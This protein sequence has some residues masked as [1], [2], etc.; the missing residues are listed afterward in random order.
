VSDFKYNIKQIAI[1]VIAWEAV[2]WIVGVSLLYYMQGVESFQFENSYM[3]IGLALVPLIIMGYFIILYWKN[4]TLTSL[5]P[6]NLLKYLTSP[7]SNIKSFYKFFFFRNAVAFFVLALANPQYGKGKNLMVSEG[8]EIMIALDISNSMRALDLDPERDR[9][10]IAKMSIDRY[11]RTLHGDKIGIVVFAGDAFLQVPLTADYRAVRMF[12]QTISPEMMTNQG[13]SISVAVDKCIQSFDM[14]NGVNKSI[15][16]MSD[17]EDHEGAAEEMVT[18]ARE[19]NI[20][21]NTVGMGTLEPAPIP[22][23]K[24]GRIVGLKKDGAGETV[25]TTLNE[26]MLMNLADAGGGSYTRAEGSYVN[27]EGLHEEIKRIEKT[28]MESS[29][30]T[31]FEDQYQWF[32]MIGLL[33][34]VGEFFISENRSGVVH[35]LQEY[36]V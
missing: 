33:F 35:K 34:L 18:S 27:L 11:L 9:L 21:V 19:M 3:L 14:D 30:Y 17:G 26:D 23:Y 10:T 2:F 20:I 7:V 12:M 13:T 32:L 28:E 29:M 36:D 24:D 31:D 4:K 5:A 25:F 8:I 1:A 22:E 16:V 15:I 6:N